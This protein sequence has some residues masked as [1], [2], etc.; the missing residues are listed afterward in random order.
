MADQVVSGMYG[1]TPALTGSLTFNSNTQGY[2]AGIQTGKYSTYLKLFSG[3][4]FKAYQNKTI[5]RDLCTRRTL[6]SGKSMQFIFTGVLDAYYHTPGKPI[7]GETSEG[8]GTA[9]QLDVAEKTIVMDDLLISSTFVD[10]LDEVLAHYDLRGEIARKL[11]YSLANAYDQKIFR[12]AAIASQ[13]GRAVA[14]QFAGCRIEIGNANKQGTA[15]HAQKLV[16]AFY[17]AAT[18]FDETNVPSEGRVAIL[19]PASYYD[20]ITTVST[21]IINRDEQGDALQGGN[22]VYSIAGIRILKSNNLPTGIA[23]SAHVDGENNDYSFAANQNLQGLIM[24]K[25]SV[26]VVEAIGPSV[27]T[28]SGDVSIMYQG[29]LIVGRLAM[30]ASHLNVAGA[31]AIHAGGDSAADATDLAATAVGTETAGVVLDIA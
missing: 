26:G 16:D 18:R 10:D 15:N 9:N 12:A 8:G 29:D 19:P 31:V 21:N 5:A 24:H 23:A 20:L 4:L 2:D 1:A 22:G 11:G 17:A 27:Q 6:R 7:L 3:E 13:Q 28:T 25:D 14:G 30:G